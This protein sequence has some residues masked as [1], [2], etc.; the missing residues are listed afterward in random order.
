MAVQVIYPVC[1]LAVTHAVTQSATQMDAVETHWDL[2]DTVNQFNLT[3]VKF[4]FL[5]TQTYLA[6]E[7][8]AFE[9]TIF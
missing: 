7:N 5:K 1:Y 3:A 8:L 4:S 9:K 2:P 6:Q